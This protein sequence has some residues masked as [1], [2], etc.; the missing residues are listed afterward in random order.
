MTMLKASTKRVLAGSASVIGTLALAGIAHADQTKSVTVSGGLDAASNPF[1]QP[2]GSNGAISSWVDIRPHFGMQTDMA[3]ISV[4]GDLRA[5]H[6]FSK[7][8]TELS[9]NLGAD[10]S[11]RLSDRTTVTAAAAFRTS[12][13]VARDQF[14]LRGDA[15]AISTAPDLIVIDPSLIGMRIRSTSIQGTVGLMHIS[16]P[17]S[18]WS[19]GANYAQ[20][21]TDTASARDYRYA[22]G[23]IGY[24][25]TLSAHTKLTASVDVGASNYLGT[26][27]GDGTSISP[28]VG[29]ATQLGPKMS[30]SAQGGAT[31]ARVNQPAGSAR[32]FTA[33]SGSFR[34]CKTGDK[35]RYCLNGSRAAVPTVL[36]GLRPVSRFS[37][38][39]GRTL[40]EKASLS[41]S[42]DYNRSGNFGGAG[43]TR[44]PDYIGARGTYS[45]NFERRLQGFVTGGVERATK[46]IP[47]RPTNFFGSIGLRFVIGDLR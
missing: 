23:R 3:S 7:Y 10:M 6:Y 32:T 25:R 40:S 18:S 43:V 46:V 38:D 21:W 44:V 30:L 34:L 22:G 11:R 20:S 9:A 14:L 8:G 41:F 17:R 5:D 26:K 1:I 36:G 37:V 47:R 31:I 13:S 27:V 39:Y 33:F 35:D 24:A 19:L 29:F 16:G 42:A 4:N 2:K 12:R 45:R 28:Q 15:A